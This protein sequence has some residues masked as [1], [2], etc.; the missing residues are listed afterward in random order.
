MLIFWSGL[1][2]DAK[3]LV[4]N[5]F[6]AMKASQPA[7]V[8]FPNNQGDITVDG[9]KAAFGIFDMLNRDGVIVGYGLLGGWACGST[10]YS[11]TLVGQ[12]LDA[13]ETSFTGLTE[14]FRCQA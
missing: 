4:R 5:G 12:D 13:V 3:V 2:K 9:Q 10:G 7:I 11:L 14:G 6:E 1:E 8:F